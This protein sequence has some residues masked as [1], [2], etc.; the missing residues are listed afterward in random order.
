MSDTRS[1]SDFSM[2]DPAVQSRPFDFYTLAHEQ[3]PVYR[4][5]ETGFYVVMRYDDLRAV[6][7]DTE[8]FSSDIGGSYFDLQGPE[9]AAL[10]ES[11]LGERGWSQVKTL[12]RTDPPLHSR[13]R[14]LVDRA[15]SPPRVQALLPRIDEICHSLIDAFIASYT[16]A[17]NEWGEC[18]FVEA[19]ALPLPGTVIAEQLGLD[20]SQ[21]ATFKRWADALVSGACRAMPREE[22]IETALT[23][24]E[25]QHFLAGIFDQRR[26]HPGEDI[27]SGLVNAEGEAGE[28][29]SMHELQNVMHQL[30]SGGF[31]TT[32]SALSH[33]LWLLLRFPGQMAK[34]RA[35]PGLLKGFVDES[36]RYESPVQGLMRRATRAVEI[37]GT[38]I[39]KDAIIIT[40]YA[41]ANHDQTKF[42][43]P[44]DFDI[45]RPNANAHIAFGYGPHS[46][47]GRTLARAEL[48]R[49]FTALLSRLDDI[50]LAAP[51]PE[52]PHHPNLLLRPMKEL[53]IRFKAAADRVI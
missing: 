22:L 29:L 14:R 33:G 44:H 30:I 6:L 49:A 5:P 39:P 11:I 28:P 37:A 21:L 16:G 51:V 1:I 53:R 9:G 17:G 46:C 47:V 32:T 12:Q 3:A 45:A 38:V 20:S 48:E 36:L 27:I 52:P 7:R 31:D 15:F 50:A 23:E 35:D 26:R 24:V 2:L 19:F 18:E 43:C 40:R 42:A 13:Y 41:A 8:T 25:M 10:Y 34:L 4:M